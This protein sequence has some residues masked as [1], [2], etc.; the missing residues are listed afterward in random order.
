VTPSSARALTRAREALGAP[1]RLHGRDLRGMDCVGLAAWAW[2][3][4]APS[5]YALRASPGPRIERELAASG[6]VRGEGPGAIVLVAP[7]PGQL[8]FG[9]ST[10][11]GVIHADLALRRVVERAAPLPW[12]ILAGWIRED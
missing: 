7:G 2:D 3:V 5:G 10:G 1:F 8:H 9:I 11:D 4:P 12:P 6:F